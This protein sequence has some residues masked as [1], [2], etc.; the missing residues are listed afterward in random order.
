MNPIRIR[1]LQRS[2]SLDDLT[3]LLHRAFAPLGRQGLHCTG[4][5]QGV[6]ITASRIRRGECFVAERRERIIGTLTLEHADRGSE[7]A[8]YRRADVASL[9]QFAVDPCAQGRG[10]GQA[11]LAWGERWACGYGYAELALETPAEATHL[12][13][14]YESLA[15]RV[16]GSLRKAGKDYRSVVLSKALAAPTHPSLWLAPRRMPGAGESLTAA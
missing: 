4:V 7:C 16:V 15:F 10:C 5:D 6:D 14:F 2:D 12:V 8:W 13:A 9:H 1:R 3:A 11:L